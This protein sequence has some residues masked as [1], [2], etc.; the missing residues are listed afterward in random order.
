MVIC[1]KNHNRCHK[2]PP[3]QRKKGKRGRIGVAEALPVL[4]GGENGSGERWKRPLQ[5]WS[6]EE[7]LGGVGRG[8]RTGEKGRWSPLA[9]SE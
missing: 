1:D 8:L 3:R 2:T 9:L 4:R 5:K 6:G 7:G